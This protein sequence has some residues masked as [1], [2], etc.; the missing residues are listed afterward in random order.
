MN[1]K[2]RENEY[3][4]TPGADSEDRRGEAPAAPQEAGPAKAGSLV[5]PSLLITGPSTWEFLAANVDTLDLSLYVDW[6]EEWPRLTEE[7]ERQKIAAQNTSGISFRD[8]NTLIYP[9]GGK[10]FFQWHLQ[11]PDIHLFLSQRPDSQS[12]TPNV[13]ASPSARLLWQHGPFAAPQAVTNWVSEMGGSVVKTK[14]SRLDLAADFSVPE[15]LSS[16]FLK[17][18]CVCR[19]RKRVFFEDDSDTETAYFGAASAPIRLRI[20]DKTRE[21]LKSP[22]KTWLPE[23][24]GEQSYARVMRV[25]F[26]IRRESLRELGIE[27]CSDL[28][29]VGGIWEYLSSTWFSL[30][31]PED[32]NTSRR[33]LHPFWLSVQSV[34]KNLGESVTIVRKRFQAKPNKDRVLAQLRGHLV[35]FASL[36]GNEHFSEALDSFQ[37]TMTSRHLDRNF[38]EDV[39]TRRVK[40][41]VPSES[42]DFDPKTWETKEVV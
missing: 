15:G 1:T 5:T 11:R 13:C 40:F 25:E 7:L 29:K 41:G 28:K 26:Q 18:H 33:A 12:T 35:S 37:D 38:D 42:I 27:E 6:G 24:W 21:L 16:E 9:T 32:K 39:Q 3:Q 19:S 10:R 34:A 2:A 8:E 20:Y 22:T 31:L 23:V 17:Q 14:V 4:H 30:R 36:N